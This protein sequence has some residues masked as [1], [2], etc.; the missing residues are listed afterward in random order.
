MITPPRIASWIKCPQ[1]VPH[2]TPPIMEHPWAPTAP[3]TDVCGP[4]SATTEQHN[5]T[6]TNDG[7]SPSATSARTSAERQRNA[8]LLATACDR[9]G[10]GFLNINEMREFAMGCGSGRYSTKGWI[11]KYAKMSRKFN[12]TVDI[13]MPVERAANLL[14]DHSGSGAFLS[15][16][17]LVSAVARVKEDRRSETRASRMAPTDPHAPVA[18]VVIDSVARIIWHDSVVDCNQSQLT[19]P[20]PSL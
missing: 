11:A 15:D 12:F 5:A 13:G 4:P 1:H 9:D 7:G 19:G 3:T 16:E 20:S 14:H 6:T 8:Q 18:V 2:H 17:R 10:N